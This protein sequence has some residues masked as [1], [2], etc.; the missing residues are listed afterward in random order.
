MNEDEKQIARIE[1]DQKSITQS[2][3]DT[4][5]VVYKTYLK[6]LHKMEVV[7]CPDDLKNLKLDSIARFFKVERF[8][9]EINENYRD[10][11]VSVFNAVANCGGSVI[12]L[13]NSDGE[14]IGYYFGTKTLDEQNPKILNNSIDALEKTL[15]GNFPGTK[16]EV[17]SELSVEISRIHGENNE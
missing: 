10:K 9:S 17:L 5:K 12:I 11:L 1:D 14:K 7:P 8:V 4:G 16:I 2:F 3:D 15:K 13:I 6:D